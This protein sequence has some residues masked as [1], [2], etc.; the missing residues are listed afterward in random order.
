[1]FRV[2]LQARWETRQ[3]DVKQ[4]RVTKRIKKIE[5]MKAEKAVRPHRETCS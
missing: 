3:R 5:G 4:H 1:V 2:Y